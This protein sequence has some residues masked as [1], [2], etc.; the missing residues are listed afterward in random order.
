MPRGEVAVR[1]FAILAAAFCVVLTQGCTTNDRDQRGPEAILVKP[2][3]APVPASA[4][5]APISWPADP[6]ANG[7]FTLPA[8]APYSQA[9]GTPVSQNVNPA[10]FLIGNRT[11]GTAASKTTVGSS[12]TSRAD[13]TMSG[14]HDH[15]A[16]TTGW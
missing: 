12:L 8:A 9:G 7:G 15:P 10:P 14:P 13:G 11:T 5:A 4:G 16:A 2:A 3:T 1:T 6:A